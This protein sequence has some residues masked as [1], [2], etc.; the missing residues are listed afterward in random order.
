[1]S[2][3]LELGKR[4]VF[5]SKTKSMAKKDNFSIKDFVS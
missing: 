3:Y 4:W 5:R 2:S 1:M